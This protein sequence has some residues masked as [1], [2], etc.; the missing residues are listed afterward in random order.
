M[1]TPMDTSQYCPHCK[2]SRDLMRPACPACCQHIDYPNVRESGSSEERAALELRVE[3]KK[4]VA[5][6]RN[7]CDQFMHLGLTLQQDSSVVVSVPARIARL[8]A[9]DRRAI[10]QSY[11][12]LVDA[13]MRTSA[14]PEDDKVRKSI[15]GRLFGTYAND[16]IYGVLSLT[17]DGLPTY[18]QVFLK[19]KDVAVQHRVSFLEMNSYL[20]VKNIA[21]AP[22]T[23][24]RGF[25]A[26]W[27]NR[28]LLG[29]A[30]IGDRVQNG[31]SLNDWQGLLVVS[32]GNDRS[33]DDFIEAHIFGPFNIDT[34]A[35]YKIVCAEFLEEEDALDC[36]I[37]AEKFANLTDLNQAT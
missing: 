10:Y 8:L 6:E 17:G 18:G 22:G 19:L 30:K 5:T 14:G 3:A 7:C 21:Y 33:K 11:D 34:I 37:F 26:V 13:G 15:G 36:K 12:K 2:A 23:V 24:P 20:F 29:L 9:S 25:R 1:H 27:E 28:N 35:S 31:Q 16:I 4:A 32:D